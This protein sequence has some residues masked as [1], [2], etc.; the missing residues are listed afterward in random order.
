MSS[1]GP[2]EPSAE[3]GGGRRRQRGLPAV[4]AAPPP[5]QGAAPPQVQEEA[6][7]LPVEA[8]AEPRRSRRQRGEAPEA[9]VVEEEQQEEQEEHEEQEN[10]GAPG[11][12]LAEDDEGPPPSALGFVADL[13]KQSVDYLKEDVYETDYKQDHS[14]GTEPYDRIKQ[15]YETVKEN[16]KDA[17]V[18]QQAQQ[19]MMELK[20]Q[21]E[22]MG[23]ASDLKVA[24]KPICK[25]VQA[26]LYLFLH[27][28]ATD[29]NQALQVA[30][31]VDQ[32]ELRGFGN[33]YGAVNALANAPPDYNQPDD[34]EERRR[35]ERAAFYAQNAESEERVDRALAEVA[36]LSAT[37]QV[38]AQ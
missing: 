38:P 13:L 4:E 1:V 20:D 36:R 18:I 37:G 27:D 25:N 34:I 30:R 31:E 6:R 26:S 17:E 35:A 10:A 14:Q 29:I 3:A 15:I 21:F 12:E 28:T 5:V 8:P 16:P 19:Q 9:P 7:Q 23:C 11:E 22:E 32:P 24:L 2:N 33:A